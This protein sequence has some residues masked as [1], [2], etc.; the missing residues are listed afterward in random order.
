MFVLLVRSEGASLLGAC[1]CVCGREWCAR[2]RSSVGRK[3]E[4]FCFASDGAAPDARRA[5]ERARL[6]PP[7]L[8]CVGR[9]RF[10]SLV[11]FTWFDSPSPVEAGAAV[12]VVL[13][14]TCGTLANGGR[15]QK[16]EE[17][18]WSF[19]PGE[20]TNKKRRA[21]PN[22]RALSA[23]S[24]RAPSSSPSSPCRASPAAA[25]PCART[26]RSA[27]AGSRP[28]AGPRRT[29]ARSRPPAAGGAE[30]RCPSSFF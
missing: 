27:P 17:G 1:V 10:A 26:G 13:S 7:A 19:P 5:S 18:D 6:I 14:F 11:F 22:G 9:G 24:D 25:A 8:R 29:R 28:P 3:R 2:V 23:P 20:N 12:V 4:A 16:K 15:K 30:P 21:A